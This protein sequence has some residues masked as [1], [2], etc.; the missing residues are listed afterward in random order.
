[1]SRCWPVFLP[2]DFLLLDGQIGVL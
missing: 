2:G 1:M